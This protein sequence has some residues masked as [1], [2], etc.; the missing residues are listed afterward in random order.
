[1]LPFTLVFIGG[2]LGSLLRYSLGLLVGATRVNLPV[3]TLIANVTAC[4]IYALVMWAAT[5]KINLSEGMKQLLLVGFCGGLST[6]SAFSAETFLL[7]K[8]GLALYAIGNILISLVLCL[9]VFYWFQN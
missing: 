7:L 1:M 4:L 9:A 2:G 5:Q 3:A 6:F 8:Q